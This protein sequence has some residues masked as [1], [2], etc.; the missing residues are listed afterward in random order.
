MNDYQ[1]LI[2]NIL[3]NGVDRGD[4]TGT[5]TRS[6]FGQQLKY[7]PSLG[8]PVDTLRKHYPR[9]AVHELIWFL[10]GADNTRYLNDNGI[11]IWDLWTIKDDP[12]KK[13]GPVYG[14]QWRNWIGPDGVGID[15]VAQVVDQIKNNPNSRRIIINGWNVG[16][17]PDE[18]LSHEDNIRA[19]KM[20]LPPCHT[21]YQ[22]YVAKGKLSLQLYSR[23]SDLITAGNYNALTSILL[24]ELLA[25]HCDLEVGE[26]I[27]TFGDV[28]IYHNFINDK[29]T[30]ELLK[31]E[32]L[33]MAKLNINTKRANLWDYK[34]DDFEITGYKGHP[35]IKLDISV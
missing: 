33:P 7:N 13:L 26:F 10:S 4:R 29:I 1:K 34:F 17:L 32:P 3:E 20:V 27:H 22:F 28:H 11:K 9:I 18:S 2:K 5:G 31:R 15:Q 6:L 14:A 21:M 24:L 25:H 16:Y 19:G 8:F 35:P 12:E 23:S 30:G